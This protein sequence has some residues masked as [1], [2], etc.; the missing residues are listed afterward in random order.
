MKTKEI[1]IADANILVDSIA[2]NLLFDFCF[3]TRR[4]LFDE[5]RLFSILFG[6]RI[7]EEFLEH[8]SRI[9]YESGL[10]R[11]NKAE[12]KGKKTDRPDTIKSHEKAISR[13]RYLEGRAG[14]ACEI[15]DWQN[16]RFCKE[17]G[18]TL[19]KNKSEKAKIDRDDLHVVYSAMAARQATPNEECDN[20]SI[21]TQDGNGF[22]RP[23]L[24]EHNINL[25]QLN[26]FFNKYLSNCQTAQCLEKSI[27]FTFELY[28]RTKRIRQ[29]RQGERVQKK[30]E[31]F[32]QFS[33]H[34]K[35]QLK[36]SEDNIEKHFSLIC[37]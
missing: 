2:A 15:F 29:E 9:D 25:I 14:G 28:H 35:E 24:A 4:R 19:K 5:S 36:I 37:V 13:L 11:Y 1:I 32:S 22:S 6:S 16:K 17:F 27:S 30:E 34:L 12:S 10:K 20:V 21:L 3:F 26:D 31:T 7:K 33:R 18:E 8:F 23:C